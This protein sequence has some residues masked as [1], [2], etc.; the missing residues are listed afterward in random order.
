MGINRITLGAQ[1]L[2]ENTDVTIRMVTSRPQPGVTLAAKVA[3]NTLT[4]YYDSRTDSVELYVSDP[5]GY[6][7]NR[8][9]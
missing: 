9:Q 3:P 7:Y 8:I 2:A 6:Q 1:P 5:T 4:G